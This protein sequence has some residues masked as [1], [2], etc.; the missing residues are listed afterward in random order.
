MHKC[1]VCGNTSNNTSHQCQ[2]SRSYL[3]WNSHECIH[4]KEMASKKNHKPGKKP[5]LF[6]NAVPQPYER[7]GFPSN[8]ASQIND[9]ETGNNVTLPLEQNIIKEEH[10]GNAVVN[11]FK[12]PR[13]SSRLTRNNEDMS[14]KNMLIAE[15]RELVL[16]LRKTM[17]ETKKNRQ[18]RLQTQNHPEFNDYFFLL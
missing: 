12:S 9:V 16:Q 5:F 17:A 1:I 6:S 11:D 8:Y 13:R 3:S 7:N 18:H 15:K 14:N 10:I 4:E 2:P